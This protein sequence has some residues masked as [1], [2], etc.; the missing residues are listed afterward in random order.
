M[1]QGESCI[2]LGKI[3]RSTNRQSALLFIMLVL[4][5]CRSA[6]LLIGE[7]TPSLVDRL[8]SHTSYS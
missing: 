6:W 8:S 7:E 1:R 2:A 5:I 3:G 4:E